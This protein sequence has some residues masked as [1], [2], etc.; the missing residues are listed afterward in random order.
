MQAL[1]K[2]MFQ[3]AIDNGTP[4]RLT[5]ETLPTQPPQPTT[6]RCSNR[7]GKPGQCKRRVPVDSKCKQ[8]DTCRGI[9]KKT[10]QK[11]LAAFRTDAAARAAVAAQVELPPG[12]KRCTTNANTPNQCKRT[13]DAASKHTK[14]DECRTIDRKSGIKRRANPEIRAQMLESHREWAQTP[15]GK[16]SIKRGN[17]TPAS[18][19]RN[20]MYS[21]LRHAGAPSR[22]LKELGTLSTSKAIRKHFKSTFAPWMNWDNH[23]KLRAN[24][25]YEAKWNIGH[26]IPCAVYKLAT[27]DDD[28]RKCFDK[29]NLY[30][31]DAKENLELRDALALTD[32]EL[33]KLHPIWPTEAQIRGL[34]WLKAQFAPTNPKAI[35][36]LAAKRKTEAERPSSSSEPV[37]ESEE[38]DESESEEEGDESESEESEGEGSESDEESE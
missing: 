10:K 33:L 31:Q 7:Q 5:I 15:A 23:G 6:R 12:Q 37:E 16:A 24:D 35:A 13:L 19:L 4:V 2:D 17:K 38:D 8:C 29:R 20:R 25:G 34:D 27:N 22:T 9:N 11:R 32:T 1:V 14:C 3:A 36:L 21:T 28:K 30:A 26:R 18:K